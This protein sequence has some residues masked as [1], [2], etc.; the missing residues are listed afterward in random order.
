MSTLPEFVQAN[1]ITAVFMGLVF[2][3]VGGFFL[4]IGVF[5]VIQLCI[6]GK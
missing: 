3:G 6:F 4:T 2:V 1:N 5:I